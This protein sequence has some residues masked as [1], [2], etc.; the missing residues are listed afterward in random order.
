[1]RR[2]WQLQEANNKLRRGKVKLSEFFRRPP[3]AGLSLERDRSPAREA[4]ELSGERQNCHA[5]D[6]A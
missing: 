1:M 5:R 2:V 6:R 3:L 4:V